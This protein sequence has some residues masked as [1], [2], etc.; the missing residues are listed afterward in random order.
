MRPLEIE[1][2][3]SFDNVTKLRLE[4]RIEEKSLSRMAEL[5]QSDSRAR[6]SWRKES[7]VYAQASVVV[8]GCDSGNA[9][10][11]F[12]SSRSRIRPRQ[13]LCFLLTVSSVELL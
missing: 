2:C 11:A 13:R 10:A 5:H 4:Q 7:E 8:I 1:L 12:S 6:F 9:H 3:F